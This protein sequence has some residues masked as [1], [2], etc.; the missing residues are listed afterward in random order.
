MLDYSTDTYVKSCHDYYITE[1]NRLK[2]PI[3]QSS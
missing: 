3:N 1:T 2:P